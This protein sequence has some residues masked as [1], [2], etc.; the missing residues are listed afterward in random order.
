M[1]ETK[2]DKGKG[3]GLLRAIKYRKIHTWEKL[4]ENKG[5]LWKLCLFRLILALSPPPVIKIVLPFLVGE[6]EAPSQREIYALF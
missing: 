6:R 1:V 2:L 5:Y 3:F 4:T